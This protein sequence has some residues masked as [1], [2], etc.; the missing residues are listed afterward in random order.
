VVAVSLLNLGNGAGAFM[1]E[2]TVIPARA[3]MWNTSYTT[4]GWFLASS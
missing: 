1:V 3:T 2:V 4:S